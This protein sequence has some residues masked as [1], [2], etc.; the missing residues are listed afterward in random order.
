MRR[1]A[2][3]CALVIGFAC[4]PAGAQAAAPGALTQVAG[5]GGC[6]MDNAV[7]AG[8]PRCSTIGH[9][10]D[11][12]ISAVVSPD[13]RFVYVAS[14]TGSSIATFSRNTTT[15]ALT[16][17]STNYCIK[18]RASPS[19]TTCPI[20][21]VGLNSVISLAMS[22][23]GKSVYAAGFYSNAVAEFARD[24][25]TGA[26]TQIAGNPCIRDVG[27][28]FANTACPLTARG[29]HTARSVAVSP[30]GKN[31]Y[32]AAQN[33]N[34]IA[35]LARDTT[36]GVLTQ[37]TGITNCIDNVIQYPS[38]GC[39]AHGL[40]I[41]GPRSVTVSPDGKTVYSTA[42]VGDSVAAFARNTTNGSLTQLTGAASCTEGIR[43][44]ST[45]LCPTRGLGLD[46][47]FSV[48]VSPDNTSV[49]V[50]SDNGNAVAEFSRNTTTGQLTQLAGSAA[51]IQGPSGIAECPT[52]G[53]GL[54]GAVYPVVSADGKNV[55]VAA[56]YGS[57]LASF[58][59]NATT[60]VLTQLAPNDNCAEDRWAPSSTNCPVATLGLYG[61][62][63]VTLSPDGKTAYVPGSV[64][65]SI[66]AWSRQLP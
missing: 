24:A 31:V 29:L 4:A 33:S 63:S 37:P 60:G 40:G 18:D 58:S 20:T 49:Y 15:G 30:D 23:D 5:T 35:T 13:G 25:T 56:F 7:P 54:D 12:A 59:R 46:G 1:L 9:G 17:G 61:A 50:A 26:L 6:I 62:R 65:D 45:T 48:T 38:P 10:L 57:S 34:A 52:R 16:Q 36:T 42:V 53:A 39:S 47:A 14:F 51:C 44:P 22:P 11:G 2:A 43:S 55:Y 8:V 3:V 19:T 21:G 32:V 66:S 28:A 64:G 41:D 27:Q